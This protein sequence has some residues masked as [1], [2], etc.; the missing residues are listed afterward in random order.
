MSTNY[1]DL[2]NIPTFGKKKEIFKEDR[3][4]IKFYCKDCKKLVEVERLNQEKYIYEC[5]ECKNKNI[6]IW[7]EETLNDFYK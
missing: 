3:W 4:P 5:K 1:N 7:T 6:S 2:I